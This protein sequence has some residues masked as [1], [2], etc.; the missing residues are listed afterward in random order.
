MEQREINSEHSWQLN[1]P[2][3]YLVVSML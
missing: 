3:S 1:T 2:I